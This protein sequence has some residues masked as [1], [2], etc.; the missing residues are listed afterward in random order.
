MLIIE[1][2]LVINIIGSTGRQSSKFFRF[3]FFK[4]FCASKCEG[5]LKYDIERIL[6]ALEYEIL[7]IKFGKYLR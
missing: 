6:K 1:I 7:N 5:L 4:V 2:L 3:A